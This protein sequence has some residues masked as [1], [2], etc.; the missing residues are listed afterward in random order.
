M[1]RNKTEKTGPIVI[2]LTG[3]HD[4]YFPGLYLPWDPTAQP[5]GQTTWDLIITSVNLVSSYINTN[6]KVLMY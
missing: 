2:D 4:D 6:T 3:A 5:Y 1:I